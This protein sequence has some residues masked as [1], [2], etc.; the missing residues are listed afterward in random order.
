MASAA[1]CWALPKLLARV[2]RQDAVSVVAVIRPKERALS[3]GLMHSPSGPESKVD[4]ADSPLGK[5]RREERIDNMI[6]L[7]DDPEDLPVLS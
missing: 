7:D 1:L 5:S 3:P 2:E 4:V 6:V